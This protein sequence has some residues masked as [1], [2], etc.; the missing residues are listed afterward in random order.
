VILEVF[1]AKKVV[2]VNFIGKN[3][4]NIFA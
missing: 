1:L 3:I 4:A 2:F